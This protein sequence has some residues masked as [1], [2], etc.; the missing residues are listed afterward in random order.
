MT[1]SNSTGTITNVPVQWTAATLNTSTNQY[2]TSIIKA[3]HSV[4][5]LCLKTWNE[6]ELE[7]KIISQE[8]TGLTSPSTVTSPYPF[9]VSQ[10]LTFDQDYEYYFFKFFNGTKQLFLLQTI[11][12]TVNATDVSQEFTVILPASI[13][14]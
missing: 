14:I 10:Q 12:K 8:G 5:L 4:H 7:F 11:G 6:N 3:Y 1:F 9:W 13:T 2:E